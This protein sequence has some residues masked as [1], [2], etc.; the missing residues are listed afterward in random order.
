MLPTAPGS[1]P[2]KADDDRRRREHEFARNAEIAS[3]IYRLSGV[4]ER[5]KQAAR[6]GLS[7]KNRLWAGATTDALASLNDGGLVGVIGTPGT[8]K[9]QIGEQAVRFFATN[10]RG[11]CHYTS[12]AELFIAIRDCYRKDA[13]RS[14]SQVIKDYTAPKLLVVDELDK[15]K[16]S[17]N[18][19]R[20]LH[21]ILDKRYREIRPTLLLGNL[22][23]DGLRRAI[24][25]PAFERLCETGL[26]IEL[27]GYTFRG[28]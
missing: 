4:P 24:G 21:L 12:A 26:Y 28:E 23:G 22:D 7:Q 19:Q 18:E 11:V 5:H 13:P 25:D 8:G 2:T 16:S 1:P 6:A 20:L 17:D 14:E 3:R 9:T 27:T 15:I 10:H